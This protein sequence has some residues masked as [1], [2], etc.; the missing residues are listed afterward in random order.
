MSKYKVYDIDVNNKVVFERADFNV[1]IKN[2]VITNDNRIVQ[3]LKTIKYLID[4]NA[5]VVL[6]S[7]LGKIKWKEPDT[8][9]EAKKKNNLAPVAVRLS[10][11]LGQEVKFVNATRGKELEDAIKAM[12]PKDVI[13]MQNT[14]YEKGEEKND[15]ELSKYWASLCEAYVNDAFCGKSLMLS[16]DAENV[17]GITIYPPYIP[18]QIP[19]FASSIIL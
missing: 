16:T 11:L 12:K 9:E 13:L 2:G 1:P 18:L 15:E 19:A 8:V 5:K 6:M 3:A 4:H 7:H 14:R 10:E 17:G